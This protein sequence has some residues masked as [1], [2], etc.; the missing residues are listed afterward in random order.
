MLPWLA[1]IL[2]AV[3]TLASAI[4]VITRR[5]P[6]ASGMWLLVVLFAVGGVY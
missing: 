6:V 2:L 5:N 3:T 4:L 1:F